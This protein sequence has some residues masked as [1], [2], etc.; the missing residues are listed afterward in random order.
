MIHSLSRLTLLPLLLLTLFCSVGSQRL[1]AIGEWQ[2]YNGTTAFRQGE[3]F[4]D[5]IYVIAGSSLCS[6][7]A[8]AGY[9]EYNRTLGLSSSSVSLIRASRDGQYLCITYANGNIDLLDAEGNI[10]NIPDLYSKS[11]NESKE[12]RSILEGEDGSFF[13]SGEYGFVQIDPSRHMILRSVQN[14]KDVDFAFCFGQRFYRSSRSGGLEYC[15]LEANAADLNQW[16]R[17]TGPASAWPMADLTLYE[18]HGA[19]QLVHGCRWPY[20]RPLFAGSGH[21]GRGHQPVPHP[22]SPA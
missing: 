7:D 18:S 22:A 9:Q 13:L 11:L 14:R 6:F 5:R 21:P 1:Y 8:D 12:T 20:L 4:Q 10:W 19:P 3:I 16:H 2:I 15:P 17:V